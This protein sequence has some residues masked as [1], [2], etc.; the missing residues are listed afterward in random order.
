MQVFKTFMK[1]TKKRLRI[2]MIYIVVFTLICVAMT[3]MSDDAT[4]FE[5]TRLKVSVIDMD[6]TE[7]SRAFCEFVGEN[8]TLVD[9][10]NDKDEII[11]ALYYN[12]ADII[13]TVSEGYSQRLST[14]QTA[15]LFYD[16]RIPG[17]RS[18]E[19]FD[20]QVKRYVT[21]VNAYVTGGMSVEDASKKACELSENRVEV[22]TLD[23]SDNADTLYD[24]DIATYFQYFAYIII[25][26]LI[27]G[28]CPTL[29]V[30][31]RKDIRN[32]TNCSCMPVTKQMSQIVLGTAIV[33][34]AIYLLFMAIAAILFNSMLFNEKGL[35]AMLNGFVYLIFTTMLALVIAVIAP[36]TKA[37]DMI[38][39]I[40]SLGM[41]FL[42]GVFVPQ[43]LLGDTVLNIGKFFPAYWYVKANNM[44]AGSNNEIFST[45]KF[46]TCI[47]IELAFSVTLFLVT[48]LI[49]KT[50]R[51][52]Q[53]I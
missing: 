28:I 7:A 38:A 47:V 24:K 17:T 10:K 27:S 42:C 1:V 40:F 51:S 23:F 21:T 45:D 4:D 5:S 46:M 12:R 53:T 34:T 37:V 13:V 2:S 29:L 50:K 19:F 31:T 15:S 25:M 30:M 22:T 32:R 20:S 16:Y 43:M 39:N 44:L 35:L 36:N 41:S 11:D 14:N 8:N 33:S 18:A 52:S 49:A 3:F 48:L 26:V 6:N 9:V